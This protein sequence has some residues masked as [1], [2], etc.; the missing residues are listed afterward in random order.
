M[1]AVTMLT[2]VCT[3]TG[4]GN[5]KPQHPKRRIAFLGDA[6]DTPAGVTIDNRNRGG[7]RWHC[8]TCGRTVELN[9]ESWRQLRDGLRHAG[10]SE[11]DMSY[12]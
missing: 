6:P 12:M 5:T 8:N 1:A 3:D 4:Q 10:V 2:I 11:W 7:A 9:A